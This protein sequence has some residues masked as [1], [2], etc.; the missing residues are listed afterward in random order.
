MNNDLG[1]EIKRTKL[2][3]LEAID[4]YV[5]LELKTGEF[6]YGYPD[7]IIYEDENEDDFENFNETEYIRFLPN[8]ELPARFFKE[9]EIKSFEPCSKEDI[10]KK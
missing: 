1:Y 10:P 6:V 5:N 2:V 7:I 9:E 8:G 4:S 3:E